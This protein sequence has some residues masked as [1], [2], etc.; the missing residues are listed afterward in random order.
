M[1]KIKTSTPGSSDFTV[2]AVWNGADFSGAPGC[3]TTRSTWRRNSA[4]YC[5][6]VSRV[7]SHDEADADVGDAGRLDLAPVFWMSDSTVVSVAGGVLSTMR[8]PVLLS[9][10]LSPPLS[11][12]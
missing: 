6:N 1:I 7:G 11:L 3:L 9:L 10:P 8:S 4:T 5:S 12:E 2:V